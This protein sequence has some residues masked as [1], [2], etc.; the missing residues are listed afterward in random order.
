MAPRSSDSPVMKLRT[1]LLYTGKRLLLLPSSTAELLSLLS[2]TEEIL[3]MV[4]QTP[5]KSINNELNPIIE[6]ISA[7]ELL[8]HADMDVNISVACCICEIMRIM[9]PENPY[10]DEQTKDFFEMVV[11]TFEKL[12]SV[13]GG[14]YTKMT[15]VLKLSSSIRL[16]VLMLDLELD[17]RELTVR[18]FKQ[19]LTVADSNSSA[20][21]F[22]MEK[23]M[24]MIIDD[25]E[26]FG[27]ELLSLIVRVVKSDNRVIV[28]IFYLSFV[29]NTLIYYTKCCSYCRLLHLFAESVEHGE[30]LVGSRI[31][32]WWP[33]DQTYY[34]GVVK[35][36]DFRNKRH[37]VLYDDGDEELLN[38]ERERWMLFE[39]VSAIPGF[40]EHAPPST[41]RVHG[42]NVKPSAA[43]VLEAIFN[44]HGDIA[45]KC[46]FREISVR[47]S[48]LE[49]VCDIVKQME[50]ETNQIHDKMEEI[51][52]QLSSIEAVKINVSWLRARLEVKNKRNGLKMCQLVGRI[53]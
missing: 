24:T 43:P 12:S 32:V 38:L 48:L 16:W 40:L 44:K 8:R 27:T 35:F 23:I 41:I 47:A 49:M 18:L 7:K 22:E 53:Y 6:G 42:Y 37:K 19:F 26:E 36:Y 2:Q 51:E 33:I 20:I 50:T 31:K 25:S 39:P 21:V 5:P 4:Q 3:S 46:V 15:K 34:P 1:Q 52:G 45:A 11:I 30:N 14:C 10:N 9:V 17:G 28:M 13:Y 29:T